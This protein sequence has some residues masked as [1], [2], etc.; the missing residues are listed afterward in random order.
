[1][2]ALPLETMIWG[3]NV[4]KYPVSCVVL[5]GSGLLSLRLHRHSGFGSPRS[6]DEDM[7]TPRQFLL[8]IQ[9][10]MV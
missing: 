7:P 8:K 9:K 10:Q 1:M 2:Y 5:C 4:I 3:R 6:N